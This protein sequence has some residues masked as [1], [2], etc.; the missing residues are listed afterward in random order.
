[1][2]ILI[3]FFFNNFFFLFSEKVTE[4][5]IQ[6]VAKKLLNTRLSLAARGDIRKLPAFD[7][8]ESALIDME[9]KSRGKKGRL[10]LF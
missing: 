2:D 8:I 1:M 10:L 3:L 7:D 4:E 9:G 5:D 6:R